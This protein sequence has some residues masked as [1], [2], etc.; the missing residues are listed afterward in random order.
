MNIYLSDMLSDTTYTSGRRFRDDHHHPLV[1]D[2]LSA[3]NEWRLKDGARQWWSTTAE[4]I[5]S[6]AELAKDPVVQRLLELA[7]VREYEEDRLSGLK[8]RNR[9]RTSSCNSD[10][11]DSRQRSRSASGSSFN[12]T[13]ASQPAGSADLKNSLIRTTL[14]ADASTTPLA[15]QKYSSLSREI[16]SVRK[17]LKQIANLE[18]RSVVLTTDEKAKISRRSSLESD[19]KLYE[20]ALEEVDRQ[21]RNLAEERMAKSQVSESSSKATSVGTTSTPQKVTFAD[22]NKS[23]RQEDEVSLSN[24]IDGPPEKEHFFC[25]LCSVRCSDKSSFLLHQNGR[26]HRNR[27][28][29][30]AEEEAKKIAATILEQKQA[31]QLK[32]KTDHAASSPKRITPKNAW[33]IS[34]PTTS[35]SPPFKLPPPPHPVPQTVASTPS[36]SLPR[37]NCPAPHATAGAR[38]TSTLNAAVSPAL[39][40]V[41]SSRKYPTPNSSFVKMAN[42]THEHKKEIWDSSPGSNRCVPLSLY[43]S[44]C[45]TATVPIF[46]PDFSSGLTTPRSSVSLADFLSPS[47]PRSKSTTSSPSLLESKQPQQMAWSSCQSSVSVTT[48]S[49]SLLQIVAEETDLREKQDKSYGKGGGSW[50]VERRQR[51]ESILEIQQVAKEEEEYERF[52]EEQKAI[53]AQIEED[54]KRQ[55][56]SRGG[57][58]ATKESKKRNTNTQKKCGGGQQSQ[59]PGLKK[60]IPGGGGRKLKS[61][62]SMY[63]SQKGTPTGSQ[64]MKN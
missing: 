22:E 38:P 57:S 39:V 28:L 51:A 6:S 20:T 4:W 47:K 58:S 12:D 23:I 1:F 43:S 16:R 14:D 13:T 64:K 44:D 5:K 46:Q 8:S 34:Q 24:T 60:K 3:G 17:R 2:V 30:L 42:K 36:K 19:L 45:T 25:T 26:K 27:S 41:Q 31:E 35:Y 48:H 21:I 50:Y 11:G 62:H 33:G 53:E 52:I 56:E 29:Q 63:S 9:R 7:D 40:A 37:R 15:K 61:S 54:L 55:Q 32:Q 59:S 49:N 10:G 18:A